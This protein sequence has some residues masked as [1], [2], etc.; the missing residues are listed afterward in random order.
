MYR[1]HRTIAS[2]AC[3]LTISG[4]L[5]SGY[6]SDVSGVKAAK[7]LSAQEFPLSSVQLLDGP[8]RRAME[9]NRAYLLR[10]EPD[11]LLAGFRREAGLPAKAEPYGGWE[12]I[13]EKG[14]YSLAGQALGHY[15]TALS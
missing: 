13:P 4:C 3:A 6:G 7:P 2:L 5:S 11:R 14:R 9:V 10:L 12:K 8:F 15:L 1:F